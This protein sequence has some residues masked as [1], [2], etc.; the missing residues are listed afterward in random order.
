MDY[1][2]SSLFVNGG[3]RESVSS[4]LGLRSSGIFQEAPESEITGTALPSGWYLLAVNRC[5]PPFE[6]KNVLRSLSANTDLIHFVI[7]KHTNSCCAEQ[8]SHGRVRWGLAHSEMGG[9]DH[10]LKM[11]TLPSFLSSIERNLRAQLQAAGGK[12]SDVDYLFDAPVELIE[13]ITGYRH[14]RIMPELGEKPF[15]VLYTT[16]ATPKRSWFRKILGI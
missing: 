13:K 7:Y 9:L 15:E 8:W 6:S 1:S 4:A 3:T 16:E 10:L 2:Y 11:G 14:D 12:K 5:D